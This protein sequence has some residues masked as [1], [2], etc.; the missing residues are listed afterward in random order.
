MALNVE[1]LLAPVS[2]EAPAGED[3]SYD[4]GRYELEQVFDSSVS[5][6][7]SGEAAGASDVD[8]RTVLRQIESQFAR[9]KDVWLA[10]YLC[11]AGARSGQ[12]EVVEAGA[13]TLAGLF[14]R[15]WENVHPQLEELGLPGRKGPCDSLAAR[16]EFL[17]PLERTILVSHPRLGA[18]SGADFERFRTGAE[19]EDGYGMFRAALQE[20]SE[21]AL[22]EAVTRLESIEEGFRRADAIFTTNAAGEPS[23]NFGPTYETLAR[24]RR[25]VSAFLTDAPETDGEDASADA[26]E[27]AVNSGGESGGGGASAGGR[28]SGRVDSREDVIRVLDLI[29]DYYRRREPSSPV[30]MVLERAKA[31]VTLDFMAVLKDIAPDGVDQ[32]VRVLVQRPSDDD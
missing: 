31:W 12:L 23:P 4:S 11:R 22:R 29:N 15:Y 25:G 2:E 28:I 19:A 18:Y 27:G 17:G 26:E 5:I 1:A 3:L 21:D 10:V 24:L 16:A 9:T 30:P 32:A 14:E 6:D 7:A 13:Q 8:W 20:L